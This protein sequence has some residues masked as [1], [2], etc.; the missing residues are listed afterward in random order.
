LP[1]AEFQNRIVCLFASDHAGRGHIHGDLLETW[2]GP[3]YFRPSVG[4]FYVWQ[5]YVLSP[6]DL[7]HVF[8][9][10]KVDRLKGVVLWENPDRHLLAK[11]TNTNLTRMPARGFNVKLQPISLTKQQ[12]NKFNAVL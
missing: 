11:A 1:E 10:P 6:A 12:L 2:G 7:L 3:K 8:K 9:K 4:Q 5:R